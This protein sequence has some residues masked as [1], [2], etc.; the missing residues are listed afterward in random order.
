MICPKCNY[1][2][3]EGHNWCPKCGSPMQEQ[4]DAGSDSLEEMMKTQP[5]ASE[6]RKKAAAEA[7]KIEKAKKDLRGT[8]IGLLC[9]SLL[10]F[11][12]VLWSLMFAFFGEDGMEFLSEE[13]AEGS[14]GE[15]GRTIVY[16]LGDA[17]E[18]NG[19]L[20]CTEILMGIVL[21]VAAIVCFYTTTYTVREMYY[22]TIPSTL[23]F[24]YLGYTIGLV[25]SYIGISD[26]GLYEELFGATYV[27]Y[28]FVAIV[29]TI[30]AF[31]SYRKKK[32]EWEY[33]TAKAKTPARKTQVGDATA[34]KNPFENPSA[35]QTESRSEGQVVR[36]AVGQ[37]VK[38]S[39]VDGSL[40]CPV[41]GEGGQPVNRIC[42]WQC[43]T[44]FI[45]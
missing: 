43:G 4:R 24:T 33:L 39:A 21:M 7:E 13:I 3:A 2:G 19:I 29:V 37:E 35:P 25:L 44:K 20:Q 5:S 16:N 26:G 12:G 10:H 23:L 38:P 32:D 14:Y 22:K 15:I 30:V 28:I 31:V 17:F 34:V 9:M 36:S 42:C 40:K 18:T 6:R 8:G 41:C 45:K 27:G 11:F 1:R